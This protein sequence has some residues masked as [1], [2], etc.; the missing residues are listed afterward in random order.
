MF[1]ASR[2]D[3]L[4]SSQVWLALTPSMTGMS[5]LLTYH[6]RSYIKCTAAATTTTT[7]T[8]RPSSVLCLVTGNSDFLTLCRSALGRR[9]D[10]LDKTHFLSGKLATSSFPH[11]T[12]WLLEEDAG[13]K[14]ALLFRQMQHLYLLENFPSPNV[15]Q[16]KSHPINCLSYCF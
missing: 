16:G 6:H 11:G 3:I 7:T 13:F 2:S 9:M 5:L 8:T 1:L 14:E 4:I 15:L 12:I 10:L